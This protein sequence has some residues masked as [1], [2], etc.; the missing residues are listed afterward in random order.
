MIISH[1]LIRKSQLLRFAAG[2]SNRSV[3][4]TGM[5]TTGAG[6]T[7]CMVKNGQ[8]YEIEAGAMVLANDG[9]CCIDEFASVKE[10]D[11]A[12]IHEAMEQQT[13]CVAKAGVVTKLNTRA[14]VIACCNPKGNYDKSLD[15]TT[16][17]AI[18]SPLLSRFVQTFNRS[19]FTILIVYLDL[20]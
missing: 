3:L 16:N 7:C 11:R 20:I 8:D 15:I 17:T 1:N 13:L 9:V 2:T 4:T 6:L 14:T 19:I 5:G 12:T 10:H 18:A